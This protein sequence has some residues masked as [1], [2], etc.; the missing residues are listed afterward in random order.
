[1]MLVEL[2]ALV[3]LA[4]EIRPA[5]SLESLPDP[6]VFQLA[7]PT[8]KE[9]E[10][11]KTRAA[12]RALA[13]THRNLPADILKKGK[14]Q[15]RKDGAW[16]WRLRLQSAGAA[17]LRVHFNRFD[18]GSSTIWLYEPGA[19]RPNT[20]DGPH[21]GKHDDLWSGVVFGDAAIVEFAPADRKKAKTLPFSIDRLSHQLQ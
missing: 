16:L 18:T 8:P 6:P 14:W 2:L 19:K 15:K 21:R 4:Q 17:G 10:E 7:A 3:T 12:G 9:L 13:G 20:I 5:G 11:A 1:M